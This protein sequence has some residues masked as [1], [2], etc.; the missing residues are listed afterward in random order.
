MRS[1]LEEFA[2]GN[3]SPETQSFKKTPAYREAMKFATINEE[4]LVDRLNEEE[5]IIFEKFLDA[6]DEANALEAVGNL[7]YGY[8]LGVLM[9]AEAFIT[10][11]DLIAGE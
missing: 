7:I 6:Q 2:H 8:K 11:G 1:I 9:T 5:K 4:K 3:I 10:G